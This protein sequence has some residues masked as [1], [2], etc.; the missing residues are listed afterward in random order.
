MSGLPLLGFASKFVLPPWL[1]LRFILMWAVG[2]ALLGLLWSWN[3]R[4]HKL[5]R[6]ADFESGVIA[7]ISN[8]TGTT[9][10]SGRIVMLKPNE[11]VPAINGLQTSYVSAKKTITVYS[12]ETVVAKA[13]ADAADATLSRQLKVFDQK[14]A[15]AND[16]ILLLQ[17]RPPVQGSPEKVCKVLEDDTNLAWDGWKK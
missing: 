12:H 5:Q 4:G 13:R 16:R 17:A 6:S 1:N 10:K 9:D 2:L 3:D 15:V 14:Y 7:A 11:V 8:A